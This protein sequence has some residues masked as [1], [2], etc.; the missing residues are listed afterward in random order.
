MK[1]LKELSTLRVGVIGAVIVAALV[2]GSTA[3]GTLGLGD[4]RYEAELANSGGVRPGDEVRVSGIGV[5]KVTRMELAGDRVIMSFRVEDDVELGVDTRLAVK[6]STLLGGRYIELTPGER[7]ELPDGRIRLAHTE[8][9]YDLQSAVEAGTPALE[10]LDGAKLRKA[11]Q[12]TT[13]AFGEIDPEL[14]GQALDG[15]TEIAA[16][17][18]RREDQ[19]A[20]LLDNATAVTKT[21]NSNKKQLFGLMGQSDRVIGELVARRELISGLLSD[22]RELTTQLTAALDENRPQLQPLLAN[23]RGITGVLARNDKSIRRTLRL[24]APTARYLT[25]ATGNGPY[26]EL[27]LPYAIIPDNLLCTTGAVP[28]CR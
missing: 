14:A 25:N 17:F 26:L 28:G 13:E 2:L 10:E 22:F 4:A 16:T 18:T 8:V 5:G 15:L 1:R 19:L 21:L 23:L 24:L 7:G 12:A 20:D 9:P 3:F 11:L 27:R 6:L